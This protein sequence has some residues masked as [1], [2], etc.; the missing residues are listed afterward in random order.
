MEDSFLRFSIVNT[1][2]R[3]IIIQQLGWQIGWFEKTY[4]FQRAD[5]VQESSPLPIAVEH[6]E[7]AQWYLRLGRTTVDPD[8][9]ERHF[10]KK[11]LLGHGNLGLHSLRG[12]F[13]TSIGTS[14]KVKPKSS[15]MTRLREALHWENMREQ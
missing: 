12:V 11:I 8:C 9:W 7:S 14:F 3:K 1:G 13:Q 6:G 15:I 10:A 4:A 5:G 2:E